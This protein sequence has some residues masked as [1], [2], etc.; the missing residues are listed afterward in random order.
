MGLVPEL[1]PWHT[2]LKDSPRIVL[3]AHG[4]HPGQ[5]GPIAVG[6]DGVLS[7]TCVV[8]EEPRVVE[9]LGPRLLLKRCKDPIGV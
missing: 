8:E 7:D 4:L 2:V 3:P 1:E 5:A 9:I 6:A